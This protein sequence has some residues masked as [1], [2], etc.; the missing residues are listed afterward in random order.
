MRLMHK[1]HIRCKG[2][3][4]VTSADWLTDEDY[5]EAY[6]YAGQYEKLKSEYRKLNAV[7][8]SSPKTDT[9]GGRS[10]LPG[11]PTEQ[12]AVK[13]LNV[14]LK[15]ALIEQA[16]LAASDNDERL[17]KSILESAG[18]HKPYEFIYPTPLVSKSQFYRFRRKFYRIISDNIT[19]RKKD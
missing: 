2:S 15:I 4:D 5:R 18:C 16:A 10:N 12:L 13:L 7:S 19:E 3:D 8:L 17:A 11:Q 9:I 1:V 6:I 14:S